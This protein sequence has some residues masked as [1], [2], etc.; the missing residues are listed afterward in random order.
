MSSSFRFSLALILLLTLAACAAPVPQPVAPSPT[1][2][3]PPVADVPYADFLTE[4]VCYG[5]QQKTALNSDHREAL[6][7]AGI[8]ACYDLT[9]QLDTRH[10]KYTGT[11]KLAYLNESATEIAD[12]VFWLYPN[13]ADVYAGQLTVSDVKTGD[14]PARVEVWYEDQSALRVELAQPLAPG[15]RVQLSMDFTGQVPAAT[16]TYGIFAYNAEYDLLALANWYPILAARDSNGWLTDRILPL[17]DAVTSETG[18]YHVVLQVPDEWQVVATGTEIRRENQ[19]QDRLVELVSGP[20]RDFMIIA[21]PN[22]I[23]SEL[24]GRSGVVREWA[25]PGYE[26]EQE[27]SLEV[28][29]RSLEFFSEQYGDY[30]FCEL[31]VVSLPLNNASGVEF[32]GLVVMEHSLYEPQ[33]DQN[34]LALV[35]SHEVSHQWWYGVVGNDVQ[36]N[37]WQDEAL[38]MVA[39]LS[40][41]EEYNAPYANGTVQYFEGA[42]QDFEQSN[43]PGEF[44]I[45]DPLSAFQ[46]QPRAYSTI[47]YRKGALF[48]W[49][50]RQRLG[51]PAFDA[52]LAKYYRQN[53]FQLVAPAV[54]L[55]AFEAQCGCDLKAFYREWGIIQ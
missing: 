33:A 36:K 27:D 5:E 15:E 31:D 48:A 20:T 55:D 1:V 39:S 2:R 45:G 35:L 29:N 43:A 53:A 6:E 17:G 42:V 23:V 38:A 11:L 19:G 8:N 49:E 51:A 28:A 13:L 34:L 14:E 52:A 10:S 40:F 12:L 50:L 46:N 3:I 44:R 25:L 30:P 18:L 4:P 26:Q 22:F 54:L 37:P 9:L 7:Q 16:T 32:P 21:S 24:E 41:L 47:V